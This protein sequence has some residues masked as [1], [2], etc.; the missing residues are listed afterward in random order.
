VLLHIYM[1]SRGLWLIFLCQQDNAVLSLTPMKINSSIYHYIL[2]VLFSSF[3][4]CINIRKSTHIKFSQ[5]TNNFQLV[6]NITVYVNGGR[7]IF[8]FSCSS[9]EY[10]LFP[11]N[12]P[13]NVG[14]Y[15][16]RYLWREAQGNTGDTEIV[17]F[18][19]HLA[20]GI[21]FVTFFCS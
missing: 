16:S 13:A 21:C 15:L 6:L 18:N 3:A 5:T 19:N 12:F 20:C 4:C 17:I 1:H 7:P 8:N 9:G 14:N 11:I 10:H 2:H